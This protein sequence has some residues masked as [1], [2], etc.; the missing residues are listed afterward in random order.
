MTWP[1]A[2]KS[3]IPTGRVRRTAKVAGLAGGQTARNYA[4]KATNLARGEEGRQ[5]AVTAA[6]PRPPSRSSTCSAT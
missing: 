6:R 4:T 3:S 5:R 2:T 1:A